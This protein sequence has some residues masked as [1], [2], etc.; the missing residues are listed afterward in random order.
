MVAVVCGVA[1]ALVAG[2]IRTA[3]VVDRYE[4]SRPFIY[5]VE[6]E[7]QSGAPRFDDLESLSA[8]E[9]VEAATFVFG[10]LI[11]PGREEPAP[12]LVFAGSLAPVGGG[13]REGRLATDGEPG[14]FAAT[15]SVVDELGLSL[16]DHMQLVTVS[17]AQSD[18][19]GFDVDVPDGPT[20][21]ATLVGVIEEAAGEADGSS[22][23]ALFDRSLLEVGDIGIAAT[24]ASASLVPS[25]TLDELRQQLD[26]LPAAEAFSIREAELIP[27]DVRTA[28]DAQ[29]RG[30][31]VLAVIVVGAA[32]VVLAQLLGRQLRLVDR[33]QEVLRSIG[34]TRVQTV[35]EPLC[36]AALVV[37]LGSLGAV[38]VA[39]TASGA[40]PLGFAREFEPDRGV[41]FD[42]LAH[43]VA[44]ALLAALVIGVLSLLLVGSRAATSDRRPTPLVDRAVRSAP[45]APTATAVRFAFG[46]GTRAGSTGTSLA[47]LVLI[48]GLA[49]AA[50]T[51]GANLVRLLDEPERYG[52]NFDLAIGQGGESV[53]DEV[54]DGLDEDPDVAAVMLYGATTAGVG[55]RSVGIVGMD[56]VRG[57]LL[58]EI[59][60]GRL[61]QGGDEIAL[62][63]R[64]ANDL[65]VDVG[66]DVE[67]ARGSSGLTFRITGIAIITSMEESDLM[68]RNGLV[69]E[70]GLLRID[71]EDG[72]S[73]AVFDLSPDAPPDAADHL[74]A[75]LGV[76][77]DPGDTPSDIVNLDRVRPVPFL[78]AGI[79]GALAILTVGHLM[80]VAVRRR[81]HDF[82]VL[83]AF[84]AT[85]GWVRRVVHWQA[86]LM[87]TLAVVLAIPIGVAAG[88]VLYRPYAE[89]IGARS[90]V[91]VPIV[92][93]AGT[94]FVLVASA[95]VVAEVS[96]R[97]LRRSRPARVLNH[98]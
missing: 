98:A 78:V 38:A 52:A 82:A 13:L 10:A 90:D 75:R 6:I 54:V 46:R 73:S 42:P 34:F 32:V 57:D 3:T 94:L 71:P 89:N 25:A 93:I 55:S 4:S 31:I 69:T 53:P 45:T 17:Q 9:D 79:I 33:E 16:G 64:V 66:D 50:L 41:R 44:A 88:A 14:E 11:S 86:T 59:I 47:G 1:L 67:L 61:P 83:R 80:L 63:R 7:Q 60:E 58:P 28:V 12:A 40:F 96:A 97:R 84:G 76:A 92:W 23:I 81:Q 51:F 95:N 43:V 18:A 36:R 37:G 85:H 20:V 91:A 29:A 77:I 74:A 68:G 15:E 65:G 30:V 22:G 19:V 49:A 48:V 56:P 35:G 62:G 21:T 70:E 24:V 5:D 26:G 2:A 27:D 39:I 87:T 8:I 72:M